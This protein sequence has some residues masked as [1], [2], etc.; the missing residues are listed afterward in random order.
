MLYDSCLLDG[1]GFLSK[2]D[3]SLLQLED[4]SAPSAAILSGIEYTGKH[5]MCELQMWISLQWEVGRFLSPPCSNSL[6][7]EYTGIHMMLCG[8]VCSS[9]LEDFSAPNSKILSGI[10]TLGFE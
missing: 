1:S 4:F 9:K 6:G 3:L 2:I 7:I 5:M 8:L 10:D